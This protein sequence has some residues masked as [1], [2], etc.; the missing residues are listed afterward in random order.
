MSK[1]DDRITSFSLIKLAMQV[2]IPDKLSDK[3]MHI[4][5]SL[6][7]TSGITYQTRADTPMRKNYSPGP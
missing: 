1:E 5:S 6:V 3:E 2:K 4:Y 7:N